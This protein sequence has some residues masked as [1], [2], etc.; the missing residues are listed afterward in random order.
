MKDFTRIKKIVMLIMG[1]GIVGCILLFIPQIRDTIITFGEDYIVHRSLSHDSWHNTMI[2]LAAQIL[3]ELVVFS[4]FYVSTKKI[5]DTDIK[6]IKYLC[7][8]FFFLIVVVNAWQADDGY[9]SHKVSYNFAVGNGIVFNVGER[10]LVSTCP[11]HTIIIGCVYKL[12]GHIYLSSLVVC[13]LYSVGAVAVLLWFQCKNNSS[14]ILATILL[15]LSKSFISFTTSGLENSLLFLLFAI[16]L[17]LY[18][19]HDLFDT[20]HITLSAFL[21][22][23]ILLARMDTAL[24]A[25]PLIGFIIF[26]RKT[27]IIKALLCTFIGISP[28]I[29]WEIFSILYYGFPFPNTAYTKLGTNFPLIDYILRGI[30]YFIGTS[31]QDAL[32]LA[33]PL[34]FMLLS[35]I[36]KS[37][38]HQAISLGV[39]LYYLYI[40]YIGGD[41]MSGRHFT[42]PF[43]VSLFCFLSEL[44]KRNI[45]IKMVNGDIGLC[46]KNKIMRFNKIIILI[47][48]SI[49][50]L[51]S[52][53][54][55]VHFP[56]GSIA[57]RLLPKS[58]NDERR[59][60]FPYTSLV[61]RVNR[62]LL[63]NLTGKDITDWN[64]DAQLSIAEIH[65]KKYKGDIIRYASGILM[66]Y[67]CDGIYVN[68]LYALGDPFLAR[69]PAKYEKGWRVGHMVREIPDGYRES[70]QTG[71]NH[72]VDPDL[73]EYLDILWDITRSDSIFTKDRI[74]KIININLG[75]YNYLLERYVEKIKNNI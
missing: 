74:E 4:L 22:S 55:L 14:V 3:F 34:L 73:H 11:L 6:K 42:V 31:M 60:Y 21:T 50:C 7:L 8:I 67:F 12:F 53:A 70:I 10:V 65:E 30:R 24:I 61:S 9:L 46:L 37:H 43:F 18:L 39:F 26:K 2:T 59:V 56:L 20:K 44:D 45:T 68:D 71:E 27:T 32:V 35:F 13:I 72:I 54:G 48:A 69:L 66:V 47:F 41:F 38:K 17:Y 51:Q 29:A 52:I 63:N 62:L 64:K 1:V 16:L 49:L 23:L 25:L 5:R 57:Q 28:F 75:K 40:I 36:G 33:L 58:G 15:I 19:K